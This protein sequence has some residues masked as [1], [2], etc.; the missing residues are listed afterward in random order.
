MYKR[1]SRA[2][3]DRFPSSKWID[4]EDPILFSVQFRHTPTHRGSLAE[5]AKNLASYVSGSRSRYVGRGATLCKEKSCRECRC[6]PLLC[7]VYPHTIAPCGTW[8]LDSSGRT[9]TAAAGDDVAGSSP[10][11]CMS[12]KT[13]RFFSDTR[14]VPIADRQSVHGHGMAMIAGWIELITGHPTSY[15]LLYTSPSPRD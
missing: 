7:W 10:K 6:G 2:C 5:L 1:Q 15:C 8:E 13:C 14:S 4:L 12:E 3:A 11:W 9:S